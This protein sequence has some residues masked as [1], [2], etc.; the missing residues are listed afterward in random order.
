MHIIR[1]YIATGLSFISFGSCVQ[2]RLP[3]TI[4]M[5]KQ[6]DSNIT[7]QNFVCGGILVDQWVCGLSYYCTYHSPCTTHEF[8]SGATW[9]VWCWNRKNTNCW[10]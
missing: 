2:E 7:P 1:V 3:D 9:Q 5:D 8:T 6:G 4:H 10:V